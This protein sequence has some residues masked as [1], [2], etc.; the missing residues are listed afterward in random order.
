MRR[1]HP[2]SNSIFP[3]QM[4][5]AS[6]DALSGVACTVATQHGNNVLRSTRQNFDI[7]S[8]SFS[9]RGVACAINILAEN[10]SI[11]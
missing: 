1:Q 3:P 6:N 4:S 2:S 8:L 9:R 5:Q 11:L 10:G 7:S